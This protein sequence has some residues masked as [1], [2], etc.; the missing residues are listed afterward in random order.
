MRNTRTRAAQMVA[1][2]LQQA[3]HDM[4]L[5]MTS[6]AALTTAMIEARKEANLSHCIGQEAFDHTGE[7]TNLLFKARSKII[8]THHSL[9]KAQADIGLRELSFGTSQGNL[10]NNFGDQAESNVVPLAA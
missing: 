9:H 7:A 4:E 8:D 5:A 3:E 1:K 10:Q 2:Q 6:M